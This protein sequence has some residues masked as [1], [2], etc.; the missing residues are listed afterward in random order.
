VWGSARRGSSNLTEDE[1]TVL[2]SLVSAIVD[3]GDPDA[4]RSFS[5][6]DEE[7]SA[8]QSLIRKGLAQETGQPGGNYFVGFG[9]GPADPSHRSIEVG[10]TDDGLSLAGQIDPLFTTFSKELL[11]RFHE[12]D[13]GT[14]RYRKKGSTAGH[15]FGDL[16]KVNK[17]MRKADFWLMAD[18]QPTRTFKKSYIGIKIRRTDVLIPDYAYYMLMHLAN[19]GVWFKPLTVE[20]VR[21]LPLQSAQ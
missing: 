10:I 4:T 2:F 1:Q 5:P 6:N 12:R 17:D 7:W 13:T 20:Q 21:S 14:G 8:V 11:L 19:Q 3:S 18:G 16:A 15:T 9:L